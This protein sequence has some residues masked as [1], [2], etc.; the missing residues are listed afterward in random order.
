MPEAFHNAVLFVFITTVVNVRTAQPESSL[1]ARLRAI[2]SFDHVDWVGFNPSEDASLSPMLE[3]INSANDDG[4]FVSLDHNNRKRGMNAMMMM[5]MRTVSIYDRE[6]DSFDLS[7]EWSNNKSAA[8][9]KGPLKYAHPRRVKV[10]WDEWKPMFY[11]EDGRFKGVMHDTLEIIAAKLNLDVE[12]V[13]NP[14]PGIWGEIVRENN[15]TTAITGATGLLGQIHRGEADLAAPGH[16]YLLDRSVLVDYSPTIVEFSIKLFVR[17]PKASEVGWQN[18]THEFEVAVW[19]A[20]AGCAFL[21][22]VMLWARTRSMADSASFVSRAM[23]YKGTPFVNRIDSLSTKII[24][25]TAL[26]MSSV[27]FIS[28][29]CEMN[30]FLAANRPRIVFRNLQDVLDNNLN[31]AFWYGSAIS[32]ILGRNPPDSPEYILNERYKNDPKGHVMSYEEGVNRVIEGRHAYMGEWMGV[33]GSKAYPCRVIE[34]PDY[35]FA[36]YQFGFIFPRGADLAGD[37]AGEV[38]KLKGAGVIY[39]ILTRYLPEKKDAGGCKDGGGG[40]DSS[41][42]SVVTLGFSNVSTPFVILAGGMFAGLALAFIERLPIMRPRLSS[43]S[44][45]E[46][47]DRDKKKELVLKKVDVILKSSLTTNAK[48]ERIQKL[49]FI[50]LSQSQE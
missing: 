47:I 22:F 27:V 28:Y 30:A 3:F 19:A 4:V 34:A 49:L 41:T 1:L 2:F 37:F 31:L 16:S 33:A 38:Y 24:A 44:K 21:I 46:A 25:V 45:D 42:S 5:M 11:R 48:V 36:D 9:A 18:Y 15:D 14:E 35:T 32:Q 23:I 17:T 50:S 29:R 12:Y 10:L 39:R 13:A 8:W 6:V 43:L 40:G 26:L 20:A 7:F